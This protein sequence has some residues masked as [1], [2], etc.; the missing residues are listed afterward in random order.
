MYLLLV[1]CGL[2]GEQRMS[3]GSSCSLS[4][5]TW[6]QGIDL[7]CQTCLASDFYLLSYYS[8]PMLSVSSVSLNSFSNG[9]S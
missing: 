3:L 4:T 1:F 9:S 2:C 8:S 5:F 6:P 7:K